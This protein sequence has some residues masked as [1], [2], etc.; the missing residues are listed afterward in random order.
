[1]LADPALR[2]IIQA[3]IAIRTAEASEKNIAALN[4]L[5]PFSRT[6]DLSRYAEVLHRAYCHLKLGSLDSDW[7][8]YERRVRL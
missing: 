8:D 4:R 1:M 3:V 5:A 7:T 2:P 6:F